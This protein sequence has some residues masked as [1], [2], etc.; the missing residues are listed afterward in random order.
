VK[1]SFDV[2]EQFSDAVETQAR[3]KPAVVA[4]VFLVVD[5]SAVGST[6]PPNAHDEASRRREARAARTRRW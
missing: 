3:P 6:P 1:G 5:G 2:F 4:G